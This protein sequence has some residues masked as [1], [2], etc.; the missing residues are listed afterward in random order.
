MTTVTALPPRP[1][2]GSMQARL[3]ENIRTLRGFR[4]ISQ[5]AIARGIGIDAAGVTARVKA[6]TEWRPSDIEKVADILGVP[7]PWLLDPVD[8]LMAKVTRGRGPGPGS[9]TT[10]YPTNP[11]ATWAFRQRERVVTSPRRAPAAAP[12]PVA[13]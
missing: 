7:W 11:R 4:G 1:A 3:T 12:V 10:Q 8:E 13:A 9:A 5:A 6:E 2:D